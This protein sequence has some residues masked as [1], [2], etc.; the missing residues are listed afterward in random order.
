MKR[1]KYMPILLILF[2]LFSFASCGDN[3]D[4]VN[5]EKTET[6]VFHSLNFP[7]ENKYVYGEGTEMK[8]LRV[9]GN[10][11]YAA[12]IDGIYQF[13]LKNRKNGWKSFCMKGENVADF[14][15]D[16]DRILAITNGKESGKL[17]KSVDRGKSYVDFTPTFAV[18]HD[19][20]TN[21]ISDSSDS[22][23]ILLNGYSGIWESIDNGNTWKQLL[24][25]WIGYVY[26]SPFHIH[27]LDNKIIIQGGVSL[28]H[29]GRLNITYNGGLTW[30]EMDFGT[31]MHGDNFVHH[32]AF[33]PK[34]VNTWIFGGMGYI[35]K[36]T[37]RGKTWN[38]KLTSS[39]ID[40]EHYTPNPL[41]YCFYSMYDS[42]DANN[43]YVIGTFGSYPNDSV[44]IHVSRDGGE[45]WKSSALVKHKA[46]FPTCATQSDDEIFIYTEKNLYAVKKED[47]LKGF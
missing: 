25:Y 5:S 12:T 41:G 4:S 42:K 35:L 9:I 39:I 34:D 23:R 44:M 18:N 24:N 40:K 45:T 27:P 28:A 11:L 46:G 6:E 13:D 47:I 15:I 2:M 31:I 16:G 33:H 36:T 14:V 22:K 17:L 21:I 38:V 20:F 29:T 37:D 8:K 3:D 1:Y 19:G 32:L 30:N 43:V 26:A 7:I 10:T